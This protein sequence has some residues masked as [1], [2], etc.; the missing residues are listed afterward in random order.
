M[1]KQ[2]DDFTHLDSEEYLVAE[3]LILRKQ[4]HM[5]EVQ[6]ILETSHVYPVIKKLLDKKICFSWENCMNGIRQRRR[7]L[8]C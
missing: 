4:L 8:C 7:I 1:M 6:Q 5:Q 3:A 2:G